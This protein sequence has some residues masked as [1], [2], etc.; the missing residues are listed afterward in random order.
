M[1]NEHVFYEEYEM[2]EREIRTLRNRINYIYSTA[3][4]EEFVASSVCSTIES[5]EDELTNLT[6]LNK[7][8]GYLIE[9]HIGSGGQ[10]SAYL[11]RDKTERPFVSK[12]SRDPYEIMIEYNAELAFKFHNVGSWHEF[13]T[14]GV[15]SG[16]VKPNYSLRKTYEILKTKLFSQKGSYCLDTT[17]IQGENL[18]KMMTIPIP[19]GVSRL[20][21]IYVFLIMMLRQIQ[22]VH[23]TL[24]Q[25]PIFNHSL[26][27]SGSYAN[28]HADIHRKNIMGTFKQFQEQTYFVPILIDYGLSINSIYLSM[29][30]Y[31][32]SFYN[33][34]LRNEKHIV[35]LN[36]INENRIFN[37]GQRKDFCSIFVSIILIFHNKL[38]LY[39]PQV[40]SICSLLGQK[41][42][43]KVLAHKKMPIVFIPA[44]KLESLEPHLE[45]LNYLLIMTMTY[46]TYERWVDLTKVFTNKN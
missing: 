17:F 26:F 10:G 25:F 30:D 21:Q 33:R 34:I 42:Y 3:A 31:E 40:N 37:L 15:N 16:K 9:K 45:I 36:H 27:E 19:P 4:L 29:V 23:F 7:A 14:L 12:M 43:S 11:I 8:N 41:L 18:E 35:P 38:S 20:K 39:R 1:L 13:R 24:N 44:A 5:I 46:S 28:H 2:A 6:S 32:G 22:S